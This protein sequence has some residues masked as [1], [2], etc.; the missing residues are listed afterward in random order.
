M[1]IF[2]FNAWGVWGNS[3]KNALTGIVLSNKLDVL[4]IQETIC[5]REKVVDYFR[6]C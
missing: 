3:K 4:L 5:F 2:S 1:I 6:P